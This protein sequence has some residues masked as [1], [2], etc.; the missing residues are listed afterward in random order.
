MTA[1]VSIAAVALLGSCGGVDDPYLAALEADP[2]A[3]YTPPGADQRL[4][5]ERAR[6]DPP[7]VSEGRQASLLRSFD[8][9][10]PASAAA[11][12]EAAVTRAQ[13]AGWQ[14]RSRGDQYATL[15][16]PGPASSTMQLTVATSTTEPTV[17]AISMTAG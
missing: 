3:A 17:V 1:A 6:K 10:G 7:S 15:T 14:L 11:A 12:I 8:T 2:L 9:E 13:A 5:A 16:R 4:S